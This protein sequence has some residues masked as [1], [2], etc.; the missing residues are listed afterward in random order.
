M[1]Q[2]TPNLPRMLTVKEVA[3]L[4][5]VRERKVYDMAAAGEI[6][7]RRLTGKLLFPADAIADWIDGGSNAPSA[8]RPDVFAG[9]HDPLLEWAIRESGSGLASLVDGSVDGLDR[10]NAGE[11]AVCGLHVPESGGWNLNLVQ[12]KDLRDV[13]LVQWALRHQGLLLRKGL[14]AAEGLAVLNGKRVA[15]R[16]PGAGGR[17]LFYQLC[18]TSSIALESF[19]ITETV[20]R[21]ETDIA[22]SIASGEADVAMG[23]ECM[24][25]QFGLGFLPHVQEHYDLLVDRRAWFSAPVQKLLSFT[26]TEPFRR[27]ADALGGYDVRGLGDVRWISP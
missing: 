4:L 22:A 2:S 5:R 13:V 8:P 12:S 10:F 1:S 17:A 23:L 3:E 14:S 19:E 25:K 16:Q 20:A 7:H 6:P 24:A 26:R 15:L 21:T 27:K 11:A 18:E 9:S